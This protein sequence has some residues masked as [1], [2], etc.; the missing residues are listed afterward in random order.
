MPDKEKFAY[1]KNLYLK[2]TGTANNKIKNCIYYC[3]S[4]GYSDFQ[5]K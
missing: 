3:I 5:V 4:K 2:T 1:K